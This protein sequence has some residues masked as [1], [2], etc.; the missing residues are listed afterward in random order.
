MAGEPA[1]VPPGSEQ[2]TDPQQRIE[3]A[4]AGLD[5]VEDRPISEHVERFD[6]VHVALTEALADIDKG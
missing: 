6:A 1:A 5:G 3:S 2:A 4:M